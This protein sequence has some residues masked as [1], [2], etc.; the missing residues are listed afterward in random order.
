MTLHHRAASQ[1]PQRSALSHLLVQGALRRVQRA[2]MRLRGL[3]IRAL[4]RACGGSCGRRLLVG[5]GFQ[6]K[7]PPHPG[8]ALGS[9]VF[10]GPGVIF[11]A[12]RGS[13]LHIGHRVRFTYAS[14]VAAAEC[15]C[16]GDDTLVAEFV[17]IRDANHG[18]AAGQ[19]ISEQPL[20]PAAVI[21]GSDVWLGRGCAVLRGSRIESGAVIG[22]NAVVR[23]TVLPGAVAVGVPART[24]RQ[25]S[26]SR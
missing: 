11:D 25:R 15:V 6:F 26:D 24:I 8:V 3:W 4:I 1:V 22:A 12:P 16:I 23:G 2:V 10:I 18:T 14:L 5:R 13:R 19:L 17:S 9:D 20:C 21:I 7:S